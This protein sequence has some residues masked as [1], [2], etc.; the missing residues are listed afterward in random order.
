MRLFVKKEEKCFD[1][2]L[3]LKIKR[4]TGFVPKDL[5]L[6]IIALT[7]KSALPHPCIKEAGVNNERLEFLGDTVLDV[8]ISE[9]LFKRFPTADEGFL[10]QMRTKIVNGKKLTEL[11]K[12]LHIDELID[13][14][15]KQVSE[16]IYEDAFEAL[17]AAIYLDRGFK[18]VKKFV[19]QK[20]MV[21]HIDLNKLRFVNNN[22]KSK[23]IEWAQKYKITIKFCTKAVSENPKKFTS[24]LLA[25]GNTLGK[26]VGNSKKKAEQ[27][28]SENALYNIKEGEFSL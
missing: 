15:T 17:I 26:G 13:I 5:S 1:R 23:I 3:F 9:L 27:A 14:N 6:Y 12:K 20:I 8:A 25:D 22:F 7:P 16:R 2:K 4:I 28:A 10:T 19:Y 24:E 21:E 18:Y 11:A